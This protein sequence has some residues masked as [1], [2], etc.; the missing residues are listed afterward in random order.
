MTDEQIE[1]VLYDLAELRSSDAKPDRETIKHD[2]CCV[3]Q[4]DR[5]YAMRCRND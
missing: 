1:Y 5:L 4:I 3:R 2:N